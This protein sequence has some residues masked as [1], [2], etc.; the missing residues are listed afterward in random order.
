MSKW[1]CSMGIGLLLIGA[2]A[3]PDPPDARPECQRAEEWVTA[4]SG[5][6]PATLKSLQPFSQDY[7]VRIFAALPAEK[8]AEIWRERLQQALDRGLTVAQRA[9]V[10]EA[11][12]LLTPELYQRGTGFPEQWRARVRQVFT[13]DEAI[14]IFESLGPSPGGGLL[15][16][17]NCNDD[18][19]CTPPKTCRLFP[20]SCTVTAS[21]CGPG[22]VDQCSE[23]CQN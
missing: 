21:G 16:P 15:P 4:H 9:V 13:R 22:G 20:T 11:I 3:S 8:K 18:F 19:E 7:R 2:E 5:D 17:C 10:H 23:F 14:E 1:R 6:L 12:D